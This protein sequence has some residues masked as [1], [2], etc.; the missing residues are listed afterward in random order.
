MPRIAR[1]IVCLAATF[2]IAASAE[3]CLAKSG[4]KSGSETR[5]SSAAKPSTTLK[6]GFVSLFNGKDL[7]GWIKRGG[8]ADYHIE[9][10]EIV[11]T[12]VANTPNTFLCTPRDYA[13]FILEVELKVD[14]G[15]NSGIQI[16]SEV[17]E[18]STE[19]TVKN[20]D[21]EMK[22]KKIAA[23]RVYGYQ[24]EID[25]SERSWSGGIYDEARRGWLNN[26][27]GDPNKK[28]REAFK[29]GEW[30]KYRIVARGNWIKTWVNG[31]PAA[32]LKDDMTAEGFIGLQVHGIGGRAEL[33]GK[34]V[35]WRNIHIREL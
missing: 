30:N 33:V 12:S 27:D 6:K 28:A 31:V 4:T 19:V 25:P 10:D 8:K 7:E 35:R 18:N 29:R 16:R 21:G 26:L 34:Q 20:S 22:E 32:D 5:T 3:V 13:N 11:G 17:N 24:V 15:L 2:L 23:G 1:V 14:D 9:G